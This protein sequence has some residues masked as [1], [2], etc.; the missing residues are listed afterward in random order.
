MMSPRIAHST[1]I[2]VVIDED[3]RT[4]GSLA[5]LLRQE[6]FRVLTLAQFP[7][8]TDLRRLR[9]ELVVVGIPGDDACSLDAFLDS[10]DTDPVTNMIPVVMLNSEL[11]N[12]HKHAG[13]LRDIMRPFL[14]DRATT[15]E[16]Q[17][18]VPA[19]IS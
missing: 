1:H 11:R 2:A 9:P 14:P 16:R 4:A 3:T 19:H 5:G 10:L 18:L 6:R 13:A 7:E 12:V 8:L 17:A 15:V